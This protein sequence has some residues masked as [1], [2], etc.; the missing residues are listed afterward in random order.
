MFLASENSFWL[1]MKISLNEA[2]NHFWGISF[3]PNE[4]FYWIYWLSFI[5]LAWIAFRLFYSREER[6]QQSFWTFCFPSSVYTHPSAILDYFF[7]FFNGILSFFWKGIFF[8]VTLWMV[9]NVNEWLTSTFGALNTNER[10]VWSSWNSFWITFWILVL[11]DLAAYLAH[12]LHHFSVFWQFHRFHHSAEVLTPF[13]ARRHH[14]VELFIHDFFKIVLV[15]LFQGFLFY[16]F[17]QQKP[18]FWLLFQAN[19]FYFIFNFFGAHL[20]HSHIWFSFGP[21]LSYVLIS[22]AQHQI[23][24]SVDPKHRN[25]NIGEIFAIWD[26]IFGTLY[27]PKEKEKLVFGVEANLTQPYP[28]PIKAFFLPFFDFFYSLF[29]LIPKKKREN[30]LN[31]SR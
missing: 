19:L 31:I 6:T 29:R 16:A 9:G 25:K 20:R 3:S 7:H 18:T 15:G 1:Q 24:H 21:I 22:P 10:F 23:H 12:A 28:N 4:R 5:P 11:N 2:M 13:T 30:A 27:V 17:V 14:P 8:A 26:W